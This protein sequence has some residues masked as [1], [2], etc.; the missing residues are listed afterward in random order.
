[1]PEK[2]NINAYDYKIE[3]TKLSDVDGG[4][5]LATV[6]KL[7]GCMSD[8][9]TP[10]EALKNVQD[11][12][13]CWIETAKELGRDIPIPD[14]YKEEDF[15]GKLTLRMPKILHKMIA[16]QAKKEECSINQLIIMYIS[17]GIGNEFGKSQIS[18]SLDTDVSSFEKLM[19]NKW[20][21]YGS[22]MHNELPLFNN[23]SDKFNLNLERDI[24][25]K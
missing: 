21:K 9:A 4:G 5:F 24:D 6:P 22:N 8:G 20:E 25:F 2:Y 12:I 11:A 15:S 3:I 23:H 13:D 7:P 10:D 18:V 19:R 16:E 1:M 14:E 17:M